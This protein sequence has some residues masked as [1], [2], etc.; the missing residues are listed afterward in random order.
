MM[1]LIS[2]AMGT[3]DAETVAARFRKAA[4]AWKKAAYN[5][6]ADAAEAF[7]GALEPTSEQEASFFFDALNDFEGWDL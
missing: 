4:I 5:N 6:A 3:T 2:T 7:V 1:S